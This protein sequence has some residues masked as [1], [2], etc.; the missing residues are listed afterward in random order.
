MSSSE[1][2][3]DRMG[4]ADEKTTTGKFVDK[5]TG[6]DKA[7]KLLDWAYNKAVEHF[8]GG[9]ANSATTAATSDAQHAGTGVSSGNTA[10]DTSGTGT[11]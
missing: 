8:E 4:H 10:T 1:Q 3:S 11:S 9:N 5:I 2:L 7:E 6:A